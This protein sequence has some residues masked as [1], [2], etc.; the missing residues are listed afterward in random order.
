VPEGALWL[1]DLYGVVVRGV[2]WQVD[3]LASPLFYE[4][5]H[6]PWPVCSEIVHHHDLPW[7]EG[8]SQQALHV[9]LEHSSIGRSFHGQRRSHPFSIDAREQ[10]GVLATV[11][12]DLEEGPLAYGRVG[13]QRSQGGVGVHL[14]DQYQAFRVDAAE[15]LFAT[16]FSRT[17][18][19]LCG[20]LG[21]FF[22]LTES[23]LSVRQTVA[24]LTLT[25]HMAK[26]SSALWE[27]VAH[28]LSSR[29]S[30]SSLVA[31]SSSLGAL[32][33]AFLGSL[34]YCARLVAYSSVFR[35]P[36][37]PR[38]GGRSEAFGT[39]FLTDSTI[40]SLRSSEYALMH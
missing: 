4:F 38:N 12:G 13:I 17:R 7:L 15:F 14:V 40:F 39:P 22:R 11:C 3:E 25:P 24:S 6:L 34:G 33:G 20:P 5:P 36:D 35:W 32:P 1:A 26:R 18:L 21:P 2:G 19:A 29:S 31:F 8:G 10:R 28:G 30:T 23:L 37:R 9:S 27:W 16:G